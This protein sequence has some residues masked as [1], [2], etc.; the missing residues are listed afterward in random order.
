MSGHHHLSIV[1]KFS[2]WLNIYHYPP[3]KT[4]ADTLISTCSAMFISYGIPKELST[5]GGPQ[6][7]STA[8]QN[9][10]GTLFSVGHSKKNIRHIQDI[11][12]NT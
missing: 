5:D 8:F 3:H 10:L 12:K 11:R 7:M 4:I 2:C 1:D 6:F 9:F